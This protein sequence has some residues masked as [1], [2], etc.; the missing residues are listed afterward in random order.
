MEIHQILTNSIVKTVHCRV[1]GKSHIART[2]SAECLMMLAERPYYVC[3]TSMLCPWISHR[4]NL[5]SICTAICRSCE[6]LHTHAK[7]RRYPTILNSPIV[8]TKKTINSQVANYS[9]REE[10]S[11]QFVIITFT[12][13]G[14]RHCD[15]PRIRKFCRKRKLLVTCTV[16]GLQIS[17]TT[18]FTF[19]FRNYTMLLLQY[20]VQPS[21]RA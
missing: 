19:L 21:W 8:V 20:S 1:H 6:W 17:F 4:Y 7:Q 9:H 2:V 11:R 5:H 14:L 12:R 18:M 16:L 3:E 13:E 15:Y 10:E